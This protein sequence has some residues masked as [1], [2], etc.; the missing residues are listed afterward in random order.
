MKPDETTYLEPYNGGVLYQIDGIKEVQNIENS[1][2]PTDQFDLIGL[3]VNVRN[4]VSSLLGGLCLT[5][6]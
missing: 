5:M 4:I 6:F 3:F 2:I 1:T